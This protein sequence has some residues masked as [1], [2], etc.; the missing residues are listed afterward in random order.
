MSKFAY[1]AL[2]LVLLAGAPAVADERRGS[3]AT[4]RQM[5]HC[6]L[7][8]VRVSP[9]EGYKAAFK[10][11]RDQFEASPAEGEAPVAVNAMNNESAG[12]TKN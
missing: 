1:A 12:E 3:S 6:V 5:A 9:N 7:A 2:L 11:C 4:P 8:R 10:A